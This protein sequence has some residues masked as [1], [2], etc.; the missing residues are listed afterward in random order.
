MPS[1]TVQTSLPLAAKAAT[2]NGEPTDELCQWAPPSLLCCTMTCP[3]P[4]KPKS[5]KKG[6]NP[7]KLE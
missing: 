3:T 2:E 6:P 7:A 5:A 1:P 4:L